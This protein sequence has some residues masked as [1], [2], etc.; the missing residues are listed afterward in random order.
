MLKFVKSLYGFGDYAAGNVAMLLGFYED[1]PMDS[2][3]VSGE[4]HLAQF[5]FFHT[6]VRKNKNAAGWRPFFGQWVPHN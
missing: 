1:V 4:A 3:T 5:I 6:A 2:E